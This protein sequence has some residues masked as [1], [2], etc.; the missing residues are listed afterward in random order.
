[1]ITIAGRHVRVVDAHVHIFPEEIGK[2]REA[3][4]VRDR[5]FHDL[6]QN[7]NSRLVTAE[8]LIESMDAAGVDHS[9]VCGFPWSDLAHCAYHNDY[10]AEAVRSWPDRLSWLGI[11]TPGAVGDDALAASCFERGAAG[12]GEFNADAQG[13]Q[14]SV[15]RT[16][17]RIAATAIAHGRPVMIHAS[18]PVGHEYPGKGRATPGE[19]A[20]LASEFP[21]LAIVAAHWGGGLLFYELMPTARP[22]LA[23]IAYDTSATTYLYDH[24]IFDHAVRIGLRNKVLFASD[25]PV[26]GQFR[27]VRKMETVDWTDPV[28][29]ELIMHG[30]AE[31]IYG[32]E[33]PK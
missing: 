13:F 33:T 31:R 30:N 3:W 28:A 16:F 6:Y 15:P 12:L 32:L 18:E 17:E 19:I 25:Y 2:Q 1:M 23:N 24:Q 29:L 7:P 9:I 10:M 26:L 5:W 20:V 22:V 11:S 21:D 4:L 8:D 14:W 27:L